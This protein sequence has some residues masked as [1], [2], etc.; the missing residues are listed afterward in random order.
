MPRERS[1]GDRRTHRDALLDAAKALLRE[2]GRD[3]ITARDL[4]AASGTNLGS[5]GYHFGGK[6]ALLDE[7]AR[8]VFE[9]WAEAV[10]TAFRH[11]PD[12]TTAESV[13]RSLERIL[14]DFD[15]LRP[16]FVGFLGIAARSSRSPEVRDE[17]AAH[18]GRQRQR[19]GSMIADWLG[20][21]ADPAYAS[22]IA[23]LL[24]AVSDGLMLQLMIDPA[25]VPS[26]RELPVACSY[27]VS[28]M[29]RPNSDRRA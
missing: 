10:T 15:V 6:D 17:L 22:S 18:Y 26:S 1:T 13:T 9:E 19:V 3:E 5:I 8:L 11:D 28:R 24:M 14:D 7:A 20:P 4:V 16:S 2:S 27:A 23:T 21:D 29:Q 25:S 12:V